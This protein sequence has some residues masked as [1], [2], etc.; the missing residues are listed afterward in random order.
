MSLRL[1]PDSIFAPPMGQH[2]VKK[3]IFS[4]V[5]RSNVF[6]FPDHLWLLRHENLISKN[7]FRPQKDEIFDFFKNRDF[8][9]KPFWNDDFAPSNSK[10]S[11]LRWVFSSS[12][13]GAKH[14]FPILTLTLSRGRG[15]M[16]PEAF[17]VLGCK[18]FVVS[19]CTQNLG[20]HLKFRA[21]DIEIYLRSLSHLDMSSGRWV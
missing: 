14:S 10:F 6:E 12:G 7:G 1:G 4:K 21:K 3:S 16:A 2:G 11:L 15:N 20:N 13:H 17:D 19:A 9:P 5:T 8:G 18:W